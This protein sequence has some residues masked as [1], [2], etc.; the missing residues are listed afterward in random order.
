MASVVDICN[1]ALGHLGDRATL[2]SIDPPEGSAQADHCARWPIARDEALSH[3]D[4]GWASRSTTTALIADELQD[5]G[6][7][8]YAYARPSDFIA[9]RELTYG[10]GV[11]V[12][13]EPGSPHFEVGTLANG[14]P[15]IF[16]GT[17]LASVRYT[18]RVN[19]PTQ[20]PPKFV[21]AL[22][23]LLASYLAGPVIKGKAGVQTA[24]AMRMQWERLASQAATLDANQKHSGTAFKPASIRARGSTAGG[25]VT[26]E[27]GPY[28]HELPYWAQG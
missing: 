12:M 13:L 22:S 26:L 11:V 18:R 17:D 3:F 9:A 23:Y 4:W 5:D 28:R 19:D 14:T 27:Q 20:Y 10:S 15:V 25:S 1:L 2:A 24:A 16:S 6:R 21:S 7:W 8:G